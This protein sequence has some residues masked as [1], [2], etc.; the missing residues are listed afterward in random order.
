MLQDFLPEGAF[1][2]VAVLV[3]FA[4]D[5]LESGL[6]DLVSGIAGEIGADFAAYGPAGP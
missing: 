3:E 5:L 6:F 1:V 4:G 2:G